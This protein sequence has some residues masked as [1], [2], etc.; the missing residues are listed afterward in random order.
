MQKL[1]KYG[2]IGLSLAVLAVI[3]LV[4]VQDAPM[5]LEVKLKVAEAVSL[6]QELDQLRIEADLQTRRSAAATE[7]ARSLN[8]QAAIDFLPVLKANMEKGEDLK[9]RL[10]AATERANQLGLELEALSGS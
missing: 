6:G 7:K 3:G 8:G 2:F 10:E 4:A 5:T 9:I 1:Y